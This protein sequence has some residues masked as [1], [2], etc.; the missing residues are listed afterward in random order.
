MDQVNS[1]RTENKFKKTEIGEIPVDWKI[2]KLKNI[3][4][5]NMGQSPPSSNCFSYENGLPFYQGKAEFGAKYPSTIKWCNSPK[6]IAEKGDVL[7]SVRAP[8]GD[9]NIAPQKSCIGRGLAAIRG[10]KSNSDYLYFILGY[11]KEKLKKIG[12][13]STFEAINK[14]V[15]YE[16]KI[17]F[18]PLPEQKKIAEILST[19]DESIEKKKEIIEKTKELKKGL[20]QELLTRG[21]GHKKFKKTEIG[22]IPVDWETIRLGDFSSICSGELCKYSKEAF[23]DTYPVYGSHGIIGYYE[24]YNFQNGFVIGRVG[25]SGSIQIISS[26][27]WATDNTLLLSIKKG[28]IDKLYLYYFLMKS[29]LSNLSTKTAQPLLTQGSLK[30]VLIALPP[31]PEQKKIAEILSTVDETIIKEIAHQERLEEN[32]KGLMQVLLTGKARVKT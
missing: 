10:I 12:Q 21:I 20:M 29:N 13:G 17:P 28:I 11:F 14:D 1:L 5:I 22:E 4:K 24:K 16:L 3:T 19:V 8:V 26:P 2:E 32:K 31:L 7:V 23:R 6:K 25:A 15:L 27:I 9:V 30:R 18:P